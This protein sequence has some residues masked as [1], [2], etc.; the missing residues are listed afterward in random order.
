[1]FII[2]PNPAQN[3]FTI[4]VK[5]WSEDHT[6]EVY[7]LWG[8]QVY[9]AIVSGFENVVN[10]TDWPSGVYYISIKD[11]NGLFLGNIKLVINR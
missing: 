10:S 8:G 3:E 7:N 5:D 1:M 2:Y 11:Q 6:I 9:G 4:Q